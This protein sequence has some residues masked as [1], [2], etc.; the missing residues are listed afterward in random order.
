MIKCGSEALAITIATERS[1]MYGLS[2]FGGWYVG[3]RKTLH[4]IGV[5]TPRK[6]RNNGDHA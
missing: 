2:V 3:D 1:L 5:V 4:Q 6:V